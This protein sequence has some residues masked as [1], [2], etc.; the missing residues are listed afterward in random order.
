M[1][2]LCIH[3]IAISD[4][5]AEIL[6]SAGAMSHLIR[7]M[8]RYIDV[9]CECSQGFINFFFIKNTHVF[10]SNIHINMNFKEKVKINPLLYRIQRIVES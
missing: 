2:V 7:T 5:A 8:D 10:E 6:N 1:S 9:L 3:S 4:K